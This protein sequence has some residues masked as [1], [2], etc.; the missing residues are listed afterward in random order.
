RPVVVTEDEPAVEAP[1]VVALARRV[2]QLFAVATTHAVRARL[3][4]SL[5]ADAAEQR[6]ARHQHGQAFAARDA[7]GHRHEQPGGIPVAELKG[8]VIQR[9]RVVRRAERYARLRARA[10]VPRVVIRRGAADGEGRAGA[11]LV[12]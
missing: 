4:T 11:P 3:D 10:L 6:L 5:V 2:V 12:R 9:T 7:G 1:G 8:R